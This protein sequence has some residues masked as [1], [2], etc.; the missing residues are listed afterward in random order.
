[1]DPGD[2]L[3]A[4]WEL[5][6]AH[7]RRLV[8]IAAVVYVPLGAL[9][10]VLSL[11]GWPGLLGANVLAFA[12][13][14]LVEGAV[15]TAVSDLRDRRRMRSLGGA[16][17][18][19]GRRLVPLATAGILATIGIL[20]GLALLVVPGLVLLT[21]W[22]L[23]GPAIM[24][25]G[26]GVRG[27]FGRSRALVEGSSWPVFGVVVL[28]LLVLVALGLAV[29]LALAPVPAGPRGFLTTAIANSLG[30]PFAAVAWTLTYYRLRDVERRRAGGY[31]PPP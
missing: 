31:T 18:A 17:E 4:T 13:L 9:V 22:L 29:G 15:V 25:E 8:A 3:R 26:T 21:W 20:A 14:F 7:L 19:A 24:V 12:A 23:I 2:I 28:T 6:R 11:A 1:M 5:Y 27:A 16:L 30:A 10:A